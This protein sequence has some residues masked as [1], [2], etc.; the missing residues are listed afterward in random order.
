MIWK[1]NRYRTFIYILLFMTII[2]FLLVSIHKADNN[3]E[4]RTFIYKELYVAIIIAWISNIIIFSVSIL[5][6]EKDSTNRFKEK[7]ISSVTVI[8]TSI[9]CIMCLFWLAVVVWR[10]NGFLYGREVHNEHGTLIVIHD[11]IL[12]VENSEY[13][14]YKPYL[15]LFRKQSGEWIRGIYEY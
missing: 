12:R 2:E 7:F 9:L 6:R 11:N 15:L 3:I 10:S 5:R 8:F 1:N 13:C 4:L 14:E